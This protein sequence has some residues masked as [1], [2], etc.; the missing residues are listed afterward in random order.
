MA[1]RSGPK[2]LPT[3]VQAWPP[4]V[5]FLES[6]LRR[7]RIDARLGQRQAG[8]R[9]LGLRH[10]DMGPRPHGRDRRAGPPDPATL[11]TCTSSPAPSA[12]ASAPLTA[13]TPRRRPQA[14]GPTAGRSASAPGGGLAASARGT[15]RRPTSSGICRNSARRTPSQAGR[16]LSG[17]ARQTPRP[18]QAFRGLRL[19]ARYQPALAGP[20][21]RVP[22]RRLAARQPA[23]R[24]R[25]TEACGPGRRDEQPVARCRRVSRCQPRG[26]AESSSPARVPLRSSVQPGASQPRRGEESDRAARTVIIR[27]PLRSCSWQARA[28][29]GPSGWDH[30][31]LRRPSPSAHRPSRANDFSRRLPGRPQPTLHSAIVARL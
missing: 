7:R 1:T 23:P 31:S 30:S 29:R 17:A 16:T 21:G 13:A 26:S 25:H 9:G 12:S 4:T 10:D 24:R 20:A 28:K 3:G 19:Q 6:Q 18:P 5:S 8:R 22:G 2:A 15:A 27:H 11:P 14:P